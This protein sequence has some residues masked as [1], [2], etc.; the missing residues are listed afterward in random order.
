MKS[1]LK[2]L[3]AQHT[4]LQD[5]IDTYVYPDIANKLLEADGVLSNLPTT[6]APHSLDGI[7]LDAGSDIR[8]GD[9]KHNSHP[10]KSGND[11]LI[12]LFEEFKE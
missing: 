12:N 3:K 4:A 5:F 7:V 1:Q 10:L 8:T 11:K 9:P 2:A 6:I